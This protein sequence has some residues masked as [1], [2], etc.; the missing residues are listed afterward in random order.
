MLE[1]GRRLTYREM[2]ESIRRT[3]ARLVRRWRLEVG[4]IVAVLAP[5]CAEFVISYFAIV[6][7]GAIVQPL[8]QRLTSEEMNRYCWIPERYLI[9]HHTLG[10]SSKK[11]A[12]RFLR[13]KVFL[14]LALFRQEG[15]CSMIGRLGLWKACVLRTSRPTMLIMYTSG[16]T[17]EAKGVLRTHANVQRHASRNAIRG[18]GYRGSDVIAIVMPLSHSSALNSQMMPVLQAGW[19]LAAV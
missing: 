10:R 9:V 16:T 11:S 3:Q 4:A 13:S 6:S 12:P 1:E 7:A 17:G 18:F 2:G 5:N 19:N 14:G 15:N 8:D